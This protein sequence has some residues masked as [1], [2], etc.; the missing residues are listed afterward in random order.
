MCRP[1]RHGAA[2]DDTAGN[3]SARRGESLPKSHYGKRT[4]RSPLVYAFPENQ[5]HGSK[6][7]SASG[8][9][10]DIRQSMGG[11]SNDADGDSPNSARYRPAK[12]P[13]SQKPWSMAICVTVAVAGVANPSARRAICIRR[14]QRYRIGPMPRC[15]WQ[16]IRSIRS[17]APIAA[18][19]SARYRGRLPFA[20]TKSSNR[21]RMIM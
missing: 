13:S 6:V 2:L 14:S 20:A 19:I 18:Q 4:A 16:H 11:R 7:G 12:R 17:D 5:H 15:S 9:P 3:S 8:R 21:V 10:F 1:P